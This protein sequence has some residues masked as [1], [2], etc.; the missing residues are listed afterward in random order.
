MFSESPR[1]TI[2][3]SP[4]S[5]DAF[6]FHPLANGR[7]DARGLEIVEILQDIE[8]LNQRCL[9]EELDVS[10][11]SVHAYAYL[12]DRY[13]IL[14]C[15][16][17]MGDGYGPVLVSREPGGIEDFAGRPIAIPGALTSATA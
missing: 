4:D 16:A 10:A 1:V 8:T 14:S 11:A 5:D 13:A 7:I 9:R 15:G 6:M 12:A 17:S 2:A 3:H